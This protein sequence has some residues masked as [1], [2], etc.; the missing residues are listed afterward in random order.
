MTAHSSQLVTSDILRHL[1][2]GWPGCHSRLLHYHWDQL[3]LLR[4]QYCL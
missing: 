3:R 2:V 1:W 4:L